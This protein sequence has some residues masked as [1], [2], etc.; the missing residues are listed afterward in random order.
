MTT[1]VRKF[2][3]MVE[4]TI[5]A[6]MT[7]T[8]AKKAIKEAAE[9]HH[10][11]AKVQTLKDDARVSELEQINEKL[12]AQ[13]LD[14]S[15]KI[16]QL[17]DALMKLRDSPNLGT[18][19]NTIQTVNALIHAINSATY[20][21]PPASYSKTEYFKAGCREALSKINLALRTVG[22]QLVA[23][24]PRASDSEL[25]IYWITEASIRPMRLMKA[26]SGVNTPEGYRAALEG[27]R[28]EDILALE[29][30]KPL[31]NTQGTLQ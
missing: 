5:P 13:L 25:F 7:D 11:S 22:A 6:T 23:D 18:T 31:I 27:L 17:T 9:H 15:G 8:Q 29:T 20:E 2:K 12:D 10:M 30:G 28:A 24:I 26:M 3:M 16:N 4:V 1:E 21:I 19:Q 14:C